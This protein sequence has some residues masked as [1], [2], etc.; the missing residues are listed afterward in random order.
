MQFFSATVE[1]RSVIVSL[2]KLLS[3]LLIQQFNPVL[4]IS[5]SHGRE[6]NSLAEI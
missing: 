5:W 2:H 1:N 4:Y 6:N 3:V